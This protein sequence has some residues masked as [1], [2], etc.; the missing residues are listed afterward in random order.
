MMGRPATPIGSRFGRLTFVERLPEKRW[1]LQCDCGEHKIALAS[2]VLKGATV[3]CGCRQA[4]VARINGAVTKRH[5]ETRTAVYGIWV[6][7]RARC[8]DPK[9]Q[10]FAMYGGRGIT[11]C[12]RWAE[13][14]EAFRDDMGPRPSLQH[15]IDR[16]DNTKGYEPDNCR[17]ATY[18]EQNNNRRGV[19]KIEYRGRQLTR[20][21]LARELGLSAEIVRSRLSRGWDVE[22]IAA[23]PLLV[24]FS[25]SRAQRVRDAVGGGK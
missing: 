1:R 20:P 15:S 12:Q 3:S 11:V 10:L 25:R 22:R 8:S 9:H 2:N 18:T 14:Y 16:I 7:M 24:A 23:T 5:G 13:S 21:E 4:E 6:A 19:P 17:W